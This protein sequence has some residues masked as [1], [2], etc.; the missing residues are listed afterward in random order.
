MLKTWKSMLVVVAIAG[1]LPAGKTTG[2]AVATGQAGTSGAQ[3][4]AQPQVQAPPPPPRPE[5]LAAADTEAKKMLLLMDRDK[6][7]KVSKQEWMAFMEAEFDRL[8]KDKNGELDVRE[9]TQ[10]LLR[11]RVGFSTPRR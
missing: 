7:G 9:L 1:V 6:N 3:N 8:D 2:A 5:S 4:T 10:S 11:T